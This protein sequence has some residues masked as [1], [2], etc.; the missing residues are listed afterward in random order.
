MSGQILVAGLSKPTAAAALGVIM[1]AFH[2]GAMFVP[3]DVGQQVEQGGFELGREVHREVAVRVVN[4][5]VGRAFAIGF[6]DQQAVDC[7]LE[8]VRVVRGIGCAPGLDLDR[9]ESTD[10]FNE[11]VRFAGETQVSIEKR[12]LDRA[13]GTRVGED[14]PSA[15]EAGCAALTP[16]DEE[17]YEGDQEEGDAKG[18]RGHWIPGWAEE[19]RRRGGRRELKLYDLPGAEGDDQDECHQKQDQRQGMRQTGGEDLPPVGMVEFGAGGHFGL[20]GGFDPFPVI[21]PGART[22]EIRADIGSTDGSHTFYPIMFAV[23]FN[24]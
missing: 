3:A 6:V 15:G 2:I 11:V 24:V 9:D 12:L 21:P 8:Y 10:L 13:P 18:E 19:I 1:G 5:A 4:D 7:H 23:I 22:V 20:V 16:R 17:K 14:H